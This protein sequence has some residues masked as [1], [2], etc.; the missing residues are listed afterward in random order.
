[1]DKYGVILARLQPIHN[2][3]L[4]LIRQ[5]LNE[6]DKV[7][8]LVGSADKLN[9][10]NPIP[11]ALRLEMAHEAINDTFGDDAKR[12]QIEPLDDL[13]DESNNTHEWGFYLFCNI[14]ERTKNP[15]F[16][17]YYSDGFEIIMSWFPPY[18]TSKLVSFKLIASGNVHDGVSAS[19]VR[20]CIWRGNKTAFEKLV[21]E[22]V[23]K[24][25]EILSQFIKVYYN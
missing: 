3:H 24:R 1:M 16:T 25:I 2:G 22:C 9:K 15:I 10:R 12:V 19:K 17:M 21:P 23:T 13:K 7:L 6:N 20:V 18:V 14:V 5:A 11:I 8:L 4:E